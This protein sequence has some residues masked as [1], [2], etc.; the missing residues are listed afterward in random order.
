MTATMWAGTVTAR[1]AAFE[2][3]RRALDCPD[4]AS[5]KPI[6]GVDLAEYA[7]VVRCMAERGF[8]ADLLE[9]IAASRGIAPS[10]WQRVHDAWRERIDSDPAI[11]V[12]YA[13]VYRRLRTGSPSAGTPA[14]TTAVSS[15]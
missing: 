8:D 9:V 10:R 4:S 7:L 1:A 13:Q 5:L 3:A 6:E 14:T 12:R 2:A 11:A 15:A